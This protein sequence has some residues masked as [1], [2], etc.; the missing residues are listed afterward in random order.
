MKFNLIVIFIIA[1]I[2]FLF[3]NYQ[4]IF[5]TGENFLPI[6]SAKQLVEGQVTL[7]HQIKLP[8]AWNLSKFNN[9]FISMYPPG[10]GILYF[11]C[12]YLSEYLGAGIKLFSLLYFAIGTWGYIKILRVHEVNITVSVIFIILTFGNWNY[13]TGYDYKLGDILAY[14][15]C[16]WIYIYSKNVARNFI[17]IRSYHLYLLYG[18]CCGLSYIIK[19]SLS[20][21]TMAIMTSV[22]ITALKKKSLFDSRTILSLSTIAL[23][24]AIPITTWMC[25]TWMEIG[26]LTSANETS[27][28]F[29]ELNTNFVIE[30]ILSVFSFLAFNLFN[31][32]YVVQ[33][34]VFFSGLTT[35]DDISLLSKNSVVAIF[36]VPISIVM[37]YVLLKE[38]KTKELFI[39]IIIPYIIYISSMALFL[40]RNLLLNSTRLHFPLF[41][42]LELYLLSTFIK[43]IKSKIIIF[44]IVFYTFTQT[45]TTYSSVKNYIIGIDKLNLK[46]YNGLNYPSF[47]NT[48]LKELQDILTSRRTN[49]KKFV[50]FVDISEDFWGG[51]G[52]LWFLTNETII[53]VMFDAWKFSNIFS[54]NYDAHNDVQFT[55]T[56]PYDVSIVFSH[57]SRNFKKK[58]IKK[59]PQIKYWVEH[60]NFHSNGPL[61][62]SGYY[63]K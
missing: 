28:V 25:I 31:T 54:D 21:I 62:I 44:M 1:I 46:S 2:S 52:S 43:S 56:M 18:L 39:N 24:A 38:R 49:H 9:E 59:F 20:I 8:I 33:H 15:Y 34:I 35:L 23:G 14:A 58:Y 22:L 16:P 32:D 27:T 41:T 61:I 60:E 40:E 17:G 10:I 7:L 42:I 26:V 57:D 37:I 29:N 36:I 5:V 63:D 6:Y 30:L 51:S 53:P 50:C 12:A 48:N 3:I 47:D 13:L 55:S 4:Y 19:F 45:A 11:P